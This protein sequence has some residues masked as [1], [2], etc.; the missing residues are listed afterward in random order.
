MKHTF[1]S[2]YKQDGG[3][4]YLDCNATSPIEPKVRDAVIQWMSDELGNAG[5]RTHEY[6]LRAK[7]AV[8][9]AREQV[10]AVVEAA[11]DE[12]IFTSGA[13]ESNNLASL[14]LAV[15]GEETNRRHIISTAI[16][17]KAVLE[18]LE[19]LEARGF[20]VTLVRPDKNGLISADSIKDALRPDTL[21]VSVMHANN[22]TGSIQ[23]LREI[24]D[25]LDDDGVYFHVDA[26]QGYGK[27]LE[28]L[29]SKRI[30]LISISG[31]KIYGPLG[32]GALVARRRGFKRPPLKPLA[33]GGGQERG[34][35]PGTLPVPL[36]VGL[37]VAAETALKELAARQ[38]R[39]RVI[40]KEALAALEPL[41]I[42]THSAPD[43]TLSHVLNFSVPGIDSEAIMVTLKDV[44]AVSNGSACTSQSYSPS[45]VLEAMGLPKEAISGA[46]RVSWSHLTPDV[47]WPLLAA[48]IE[49]LR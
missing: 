11:G 5:S 22:E 28:P 26:A 29:R 25:I 38:E 21:L 41:G 9:Q 27:D 19:A 32:V 44:A 45:H 17:H 20:S 43:H 24:A 49:T 2:T 47:D 36:I 8:Q 14:G 7:R 4:V 23:P 34:L 15:F 12:I 40:R 13:T 33:Y 10:A 16:E 31:H 1:A 48:R 37:G 6:G 46:I 39:C 35:R 42:R 3:P 30:D 18:P